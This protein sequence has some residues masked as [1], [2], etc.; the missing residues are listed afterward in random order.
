MISLKEAERVGEPPDYSRVREKRGGGS[1]RLSNEKIMLS[2][3]CRYYP[4]MRCC[5]Q[6]RVTL[7]VLSS[8]LGQVHALVMVRGS[9]S[10]T[11]LPPTQLI[12]EKSDEQGEV[13]DYLRL[14]QG[15]VRNN[16]TKEKSLYEYWSS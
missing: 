14:S 9:R 16:N 13:L 10:P 15:L 7:P 1:D 6:L 8:D 11:S 5:A 12:P 4:A 3:F 2:S